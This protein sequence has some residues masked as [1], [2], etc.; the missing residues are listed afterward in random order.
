M[1]TG[2]AVGGNAVEG[3]LFARFG[4]RYLPQLYIGLG[5]L[6][7]LSV[8]A[9]TAMVARGNRGRLYVRLLLAMA[10]VL[11]VER[12]VLG[13]GFVWFYPV[14]WLAMCGMGNLQGLI[15]WGFAGLVCDMRQAKRL[16]P[17]FAAGAVLAAIVGGLATPPL[18]ALLHAENML[19]V[20]S[21]L[22]IIAVGLGTLLVRK[23]AA[24]PPPDPDASFIR[25]IRQGFDAVVRSRMLTWLA[26]GAVLFSLLYFSLSF[27]FARAAAL[28]YPNPDRL[29]GFLGIF[30]AISTGS[31]LVLGLVFANRFF[32]RFG[33]MT[34]VLVFPFIYVLGFAILAARPEFPILV[35]F[36]FL[37][38]T[39]LW[40]IAGT[41]FHATFNAIPSERRD[42]ARSFVDG[43]GTQAGTILAGLVLIAGQLAL[44][45]QEL[46]VLGAA[47]AMLTVVAAWLARRQYRPALFDALRA[48]QPDVFIA[49]EKPFGGFAR[50][51]AAMEVATAGLSDPDPRIR[52]VAAEVIANSD[53]DTAR[54]RLLDVLSDPDPQVRVAVIRGVGPEWRRARAALDDSD[55]EVRC[56]AAATLLRNGESEPAGSVLKAICE[57]DDDEIRRLAISCLGPESLDRLETGLDDVAPRVRRAAAA[58]LAKAAPER[59]CDEILAGRHEQLLL[60]E[61]EEVPEHRRKAV[62]AYTE[63]KAAV[64]RRLMRL[65]QSSALAGRGEADALLTESL[66]RTAESSALLA[67]SAVRLL[68][69]PG[70]LQA[71]IAGLRSRDSEQRANALEMLDA[72]EPA[73]V[74]PLLPIWEPAPVGRPAD[75]WLDEVLADNDE[76]LRACAEL[77]DAT[78]SRSVKTLATLPLMERVL[79][80]RKV[81]LFEELAPSDLKH[82]AAIATERVYPDAS[83]LVRQGDSGDELYIIVSGRVRVLTDGQPVAARSAGDFIGEMAILTREPRSAT[84]VAEGDVR[85]LCVEQRQFEVMLRDRP[86]IGLAVIKTLAQRLRERPSAGV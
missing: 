21:V 65:A 58:G 2:G 8:L 28:Q 9:G 13:A 63:E 33:L 51:A 78:S 31:A 23:I 44:S 50:D 84:V 27:P 56:I 35:G 71:A 32:G 74:R 67:F 57:S 81:A 85:V 16:F 48:G 82:V 86:E 66:R 7:L 70:R 20:W 72:A 73:L 46:Y 45:N 79:F 34:G 10:L 37:Q 47:I 77:V 53:D 64:A 1:A 6:N 25:D 19:L 39:W 61:L 62:R 43:I 76:W 55:A 15:A 60:D 18:V 17:L 40:G 41:A 80:L 52:R 36:R 4:T 29:A 54:S 69:N 12:L 49:E 5:V 42:Q 68:S 26:V 75:G 22:L 83:K 59:A 11:I 38:M 24:E 30:Q 14:L 3:L